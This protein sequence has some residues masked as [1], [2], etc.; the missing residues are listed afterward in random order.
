MKHELVLLWIS[1][2]FTVVEQRAVFGVSVVPG[3]EKKTSSKSAS[4][5]KC[6]SSIGAFFTHLCPVLVD[7]V[8]SECPASERVD[9]AKRSTYPKILPSQENPELE[10]ASVEFIA[11]VPLSA[12]LAGASLALS[13]AGIPCPIIQTAANTDTVNDHFEMSPSDM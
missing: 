10:A 13:P 6:V 3:G 11:S 1:E 5:R 8:A 12:S 4:R 9:A 2:R 7:F